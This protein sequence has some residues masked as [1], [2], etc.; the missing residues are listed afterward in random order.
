MII[1]VDIDDT[2]CKTEST[3]YSNST[4]YFDKIS[5]INSLYDSGHTIIYWTAR[6]S[7]SGNDYYSLTENQLK[8]WGVKYHELHT[9]KPYYD[10][11]IDDRT[12]SNIDDLNL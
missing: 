11:F 7:L 12:L 1:Y 8:S 5:K 6:G 2:I 10:I 9:T 3:D 4:P